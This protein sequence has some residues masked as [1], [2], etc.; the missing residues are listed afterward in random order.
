M[1]AKRSQLCLFAKPSD[2]TEG[3]TSGTEQFALRCVW[4]IRHWCVRVSLLRRKELRGRRE[5]DVG[6]ETRTKLGC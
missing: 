5:L 6:P 3:D 2:S 1:R 4:D